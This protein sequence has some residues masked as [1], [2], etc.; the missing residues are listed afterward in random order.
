MVKI[1]VGI[2]AW[3]FYRATLCVSAAQS[4]LW[5]DVQPSGVTPIGQDWTNVRG[6]RG[7]GAPSLT[8]IFLYILIFQVLGIL[9][10][11]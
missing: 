5:P 3:N 1:P 4:L 11:S 8:L 2:L 10:Y 9:L 6:L 7:L